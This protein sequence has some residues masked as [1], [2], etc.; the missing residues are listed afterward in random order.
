MTDSAQVVQYDDY[1]P[2]QLLHLTQVPMPVPGPGE[3]LV[4][5]RAASVNPIDEQ[6]RSGA[7]RQFY[8]VAFPGTQGADLAGVVIAVGSGVGDWRIGDEVIGWQR[9]WTTHAS[10]VVVPATQLV[11]RPA[12]LEWAVAGSLYMVGATATALVEASAATDGEV[13]LV[14]AAPGG[15]GSTVVQLLAERGVTVLGVGSAASAAWLSEIGAVPL[16]YGE[17]LIDR[18]R[19]AAGERSVDAVIDLHGPDYLDLGVAL[20][21][22]TER[23][24]TAVSFARAHER[25]AT[26]T[27][28]AGATTPEMLTGI[29]ERVTDGRLRVRVDRTYPLAD[30]VAAMEHLA[31]GRQAGKVVLTGG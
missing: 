25:G 13:V 31:S 9:A 14:S 26:I 6:R 19:A 10:H 11:A 30:V 21:I 1:G 16:T 8:P 29:V 18:V 5:M 20:G 27:G 4:E 22:A 23:L 3:V 17:G 2:P 7:L 28:A 12:D 24:V 15:V